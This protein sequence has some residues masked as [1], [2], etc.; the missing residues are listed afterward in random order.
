M[1]ISDTWSGVHVRKLRRVMKEQALFFNAMAGILDSIAIAADEE[2]DPV[3]RAAAL[4]EAR[5][6]LEE[7]KGRLLGVPEVT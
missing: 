1:Q 2:G 3:A 5:E 6:K 7:L 4:A